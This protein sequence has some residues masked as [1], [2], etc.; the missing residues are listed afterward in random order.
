MIRMK[1]TSNIPDLRGKVVQIPNKLNN[2]AVDIGLG[3]AK[4][5]VKSAKLRSPRFTGSLARSIGITGHPSPKV[6]TVGFM[7]GTPGAAYG[8]AVENG[9]TPH[10]IPIEWIEDHRASPGTRGQYIE[11][12]QGWML[13]HSANTRTKFME[14]ALDASV[15]AIPKIITRELDKKL[16]GGK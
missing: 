11:N 1:L 14:S 5:V 4:W 6:Y 16:K 3:W 2:S 13:S 10:W 9:W 12:P 8:M 7:D 15:R